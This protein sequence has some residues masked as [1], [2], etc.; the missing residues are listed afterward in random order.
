MKKTIIII[1]AIIIRTTFAGAQTL[2]PGFDIDEYIEMIKIMKKQFPGFTKKKFPEPQF[3]QLLYASPETDLKNQ[4]NLWLYKGNIAVV[5]IRG[6]TPNMPSWS[7][8][9]YTAM[10]PASGTV[11]LNDTTTVT[12]KLASDSLAAVHAGWLVGMAS[13]A[14][15][16]EKHLVQLKDSLRINNVI[17]TGHSQGGAIS[18]LLTAYLHYRIKDGKL[19]QFNIKTYS[20]AAPKPGNVYFAYDYELITGN[21]AFNVV[22]TADWVPQVP[23]SVET[24]DDLNPINPFVVAKDGLSKL[25][26]PKNI[27]LKHVFNKV[28]KSADKTRDYYIYYFGKKMY[29]IITKYSPQLKEPQYYKSMDYVRTGNTV[30]FR[31]GKN[32]LKERPYTAKDI[33][34]NIFRHHFFSSYLM[35]AEEYKKQH[36]NVK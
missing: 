5:S 35:L 34:K 1:L 28:K 14:R 7:E 29:P 2:K 27:V 11:Q 9:F 21:M 20:S 36:I 3:S 33:S 31:P 17:V 6:T 13:I 22:N 10:V 15:D 16:V 24:I 8:N 19:P 25:K 30:I 18:Y 32:Y 23:L 26:F 12:Y 4:W